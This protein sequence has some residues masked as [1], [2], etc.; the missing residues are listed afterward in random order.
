MPGV[1][2]DATFAVTNLHDAGSRQRPGWPKKPLRNHLKFC[3]QSPLLPFSR[4]IRPSLFS[5]VLNRHAQFDDA[6]VFKCPL[7]AS[8]RGFLAV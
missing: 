4:R 3:E 1:Q 5:P 8:R 2:P 7:I 6:P